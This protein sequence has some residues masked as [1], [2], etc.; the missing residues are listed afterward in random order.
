MD[1][2]NDTIYFTTFT[3]QKKGEFEVISNFASKENQ[4]KEI[5]K[6]GYKNKLYQE[7]SITS[8]SLQGLK[9]AKNR[10]PLLVFIHIGV[11][12]KITNLKQK[13]KPTKKISFKQ[14]TGKE[15]TPNKNV[16]A[17]ISE[18]IK[19]LANLPKYKKIGEMAL[20]MFY[21]KFKGKNI[22]DKIEVGTGLEDKIFGKLDKAGFVEYGEG[23]DKEAILTEQGFKIIESISARHQTLKAKKSGTDLFP[24][25]AGTKIINDKGLQFIQ[26]FVDLDNTTINDKTIESFLTDLANAV[27][28]GEIN[29]KHPYKDVINDISQRL[30]KLYQNTNSASILIHIN[31]RN[32]LLELIE[33]EKSGLGFLPIVVAAAA[34]KAVEYLTHKGLSGIDEDVLDELANLF[35]N[36]KPNK[37]VKVSKISSELLQKIN[38]AIGKKI[39]VSN[40]IVRG[41][42]VIHI[43]DFHSKHSEK[44]NDQIPIS[45]ENFIYH[46]IVVLNFDEVE[47][48]PKDNRKNKLDTLLFYKRIGNHY[49]VV[50]E[51]L[52]ENNTLRLKTMWIK[53]KKKPLKQSLSGF[54]SIS[55][56]AA[57]NPHVKVAPQYKRPKRLV[58]KVKLQ[59]KIKTP[60]PT[61]SGILSTEQ[62]AG[63]TYKELALNPYYTKILGK[64]ATNFDM[65]IHGEPGSGKTVFLLKLANYLAENFGKVIYITTEEFG[66]ATLT[67]KIKDFGI[68]S[69]NLFFTDKLDKVNLSDYNFAFI[70]SVNHSGLKLE[71]YK[72][73]REK[74]PNTAVILIL[75]T[76][77]AGN[78]KGGKD[79]PHEVEIC[80]R[81]FKNEKGQ[82]MIEI[83]K[84]GI[85]VKS[86]KANKKTA[87]RDK[88]HHFWSIVSVDGKNYP[89]G[90][91]VIEK[92]GKYIYNTT[93]VPVEKTIKPTGL[94]GF[95]FIKDF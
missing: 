95:K 31:D 21:N 55:P 58:D 56:G 32:K 67:K 44:L 50:Q 52:E 73:L 43:Q 17:S 28:R 26:R 84:V 85:L 89:F 60:K 33:K 61:L 69:K 3:R 8:V 90:F 22:E 64:P 25:L 5:L 18:T 75:Q 80:A 4:I 7:G 78:Y 19:Q 15:I 86:E 38:K 53:N 30:Y 23:Y 9:L 54:V 10:K 65:C 74:S 35:E 39:N 91:L 29:K 2:K 72:R 94:A 92:N 51:V 48:Q 37:V 41:N 93:L 6:R 57:I 47:F 36:P 68:N 11:P 87:T 1:K 49:Y 16:K 82:R 27:K 40:L 88:I 70:D 59:K 71:D 62:M 77:K 24:E 79:W 13:N 45:T 63:F 81:L 76:T 12:F 20:G 46:P 83:T 14:S 34:G 42:E 66:S